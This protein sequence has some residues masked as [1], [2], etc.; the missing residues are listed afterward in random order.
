MPFREGNRHLTLT[1]LTMVIGLMLIFAAGQ[2][3]ASE[4]EEDER[5]AY[6]AEQAENAKEREQADRAY[7]DCLTKFAAD[8]VDTINTRTDATIRLERAAERKDDALDRLLFVTALTREIPPEATAE[9]FDAALRARVAAQEDFEKVKRQ[10]DEVRADNPYA[11][12]KAT[13]TR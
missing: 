11:K 12:P 9:E 1:I 2:L 4:R 8:L 7:A 5:A 10:V 13:C 6:L 3:W